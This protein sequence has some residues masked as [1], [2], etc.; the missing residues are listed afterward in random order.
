MPMIYNSTR[1][2][3]PLLR[4]VFSDGTERGVRCHW[5]MMAKLGTQRIG[6]YGRYRC[7]VSLLLLLDNIELGSD[8]I[9]LHSPASCLV[10]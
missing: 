2:G 6:R 1:R 7:V 4:I 8:G 5:M 3:G 10:P 9:Q